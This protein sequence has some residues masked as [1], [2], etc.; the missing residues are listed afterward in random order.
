V[1]V[2]KQDGSMNTAVFEFNYFKRE[3]KLVKSFVP[4]KKN[5][6]MF[7]EF[8]VSEKNFSFRE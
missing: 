6:R 8:L 2:I 7:C 1:N 4:E 3:I 5:N